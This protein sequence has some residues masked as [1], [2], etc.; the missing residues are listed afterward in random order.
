MIKKIY[1]L[2]YFRQIGFYSSDLITP[3]FS[4]T[5]AQSLSSASNGFVIPN[6]IKQGHNLIYC[7]NINPGHHAQTNKYGGYCYLNNG[8][9]CAKALLSDK[10]LNYSKIAILDLDYH[11]GDG[12]GQIFQSDPNVLTVSIHIN[13]LYDYPFYAGYQDENTDSNINL[14]FEPKCDIS[15]YLDLISISMEKIN[16]FDP[17]VLIIAFGGDTY[18]NDLDA[19]EPNRTQIDIQD[20]KKISS[21]IYSSWINKLKPT[22][23][24]IVITQ[25]GGYNMENI[26]QIVESFLSGF[27]LS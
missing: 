15:Q 18:K 13:P 23:K 4:N 5:F 26:G 9:I 3:I 21:Q 19:L 14:T 2:E 16:Q 7:A 22:P 20:Y 8:G 1:K 12:T 6:Y 27:D 17:D 25:E 10:Q 11:A 24:P